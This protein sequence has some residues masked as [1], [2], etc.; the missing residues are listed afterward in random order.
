MTGRKYHHMYL[1]PYTIYLI[2]ET[3][4]EMKQYRFPVFLRFDKNSLSSRAAW[5]TTPLVQRES[6]KGRF[7]RRAI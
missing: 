4:A 3:S 5:N 6:A 2:L 1:P 7:V